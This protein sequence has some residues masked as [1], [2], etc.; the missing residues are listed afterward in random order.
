[1]STRQPKHQLGVPANYQTRRARAPLEKRKSPRA[2]PGDR[3]INYST[4]RVCFV[5]ANESHYR[6][7][8]VIPARPD[9]DKISLIAHS[10]V[11]SM[12]SIVFIG[13]YSNSV[14]ST[15][16][17]QDM[18]PA[19]ITLLDFRA[20]QLQPG[21]RALLYLLT[22]AVPEKCECTLSASA[23]RENGLLTSPP[24][25]NQAYKIKGIN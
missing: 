22:M 7:H 13:G 12:W 18:H 17:A 24:M 10:K 8:H 11:G 5:Y 16:M 9:V 20:F 3:P 1:M 6:S 23:D 14:D 21:G 19:S 2:V 25:D 15:F 4:D